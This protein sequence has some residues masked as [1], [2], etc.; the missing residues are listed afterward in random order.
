M[1]EVGLTGEIRAISHAQARLGEIQKM[2]FTRC[3]LP[4]GNMKHMKPLKD[5]DVTGF[6][7]I[8]EAMENLF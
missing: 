5:F 8:A 1:G 2:G 3:L 6:K 7:T 4:A